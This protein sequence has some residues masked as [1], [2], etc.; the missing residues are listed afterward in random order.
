MAKSRAT[1][2]RARAT[3]RR[4]SLPTRT[5]LLARLRLASPRTRELAL[6]GAPLTAA[7]LA[8]IERRLG[9]PLP[10]PLRGF[11]LAVG[12]GGRGPRGTWFTIADGVAKLASPTDAAAEPPFA[13][14]VLDRAIAEK[15]TDESYVLHDPDEEEPPLCGVL[16]VADAGDGLLYAVVMQGKHAGQVWLVGEAW[17]PE[18]DAA[19]KPVDFV[20]W[21]LAGLDGAAPTVT[22]TTAIDPS[23]PKALRAALEKPAKARKLGLNDFAGPK[24]PDVFDRLPNLEELSISQCTATALPSSMRALV[25]LRRLWLSSMKNLVDLEA[26]TSLRGLKLLNLSRSSQIE[27]PASITGLAS[28]EVLVLSFTKLTSLPAAL[29]EL[30]RLHRLDLDL[31]FQLDL[32]QAWPVIA[33]LP[34]LRALTLSKSRLVRWPSTLHRPPKLEQ[35]DLREAELPA[36]QLDRVRAALPGVSILV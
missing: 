8:V 19:S 5:A 15:R 11:V 23:W 24:L 25:G 36:G 6:L 17:S 9:V 4:P 13:P 22:T 35:L 7:K 20:A 2:S 28:L 34:A 27:L 1:P 26:I 12:N 33:R 14:R 10:E 32:R 3:R 29:V 18:L 16:P 31:C 21:Y 30:P